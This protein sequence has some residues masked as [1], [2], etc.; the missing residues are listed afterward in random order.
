M[1]LQIICACRVA[2]VQNKQYRR[3]LIIKRLHTAVS[4]IWSDVTTKPREPRHSPDGCRVLIPVLP[5]RVRVL[6]PALS[7]YTPKYHLLNCLEGFLPPSRIFLYEAAISC[8]PTWIFLIIY[9]SFELM[10]T[11]YNLFVQIEMR[12][13]RVFSLHLPMDERYSTLLALIDSSPTCMIYSLFIHSV[14]PRLTTPSILSP[15]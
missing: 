6:A 7:L 9:L 4:L 5:V 8:T 2:K 3:F 15:R 14:L 1:K 11:T 13:H 10:C 12:V